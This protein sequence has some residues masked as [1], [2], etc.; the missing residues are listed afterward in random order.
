MIWFWVR[1]LASFWSGVLMG[2]LLARAVRWAT[3]MDGASE[4]VVTVILV[5][6]GAGVG[7]IWAADVERQG[8]R[9]VWSRAAD[10]ERQ[11]VRFVWS[12]AGFARA[13]CVLAAVVVG[14]VVTRYAG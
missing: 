8:V 5:G 7:V 6:L 3:G 14:F 9:F 10:V 13:A 12:R 2:I 1:R 11:G 4:V